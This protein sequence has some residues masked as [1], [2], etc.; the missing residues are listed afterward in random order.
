METRTPKYLPYFCSYMAEFFNYE[1]MPSSIT[2]QQ[3]SEEPNMY[4]AFLR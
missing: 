4:E 3:T 2:V 1:V